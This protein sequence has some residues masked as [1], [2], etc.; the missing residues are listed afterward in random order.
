[1][2]RM[3]RTILVATL[4]LLIAGCQAPSSQLCWRTGSPE[5]NQHGGPA[6]HDEGSNP[7]N[8]DERYCTNDD[9]KQP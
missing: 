2:L 5:Y 3:K 9:Y 1:M 8:P 6:P 4:A 7:F